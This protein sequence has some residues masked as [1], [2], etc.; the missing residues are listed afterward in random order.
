MSI[1][2]PKGGIRTEQLKRKLCQFPGC[3]DYYMGTGFSKYCGEHRKKQYRKEINKSRLKIE[4]ESANQTIKHNYER[5]QDI[6]YNCELCGESFIIT[7]Y[8]GVTIYPKFCQEHRSEYKRLF[9]KAMHNIIP[10]IPQTPSI[11]IIN[12][13]SI[14]L[15]EDLDII[16]E[17]SAI[18]EV[19]V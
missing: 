1:Q 11:E 19:M 15:E 6:N 10:V 8:P 9:Y 5:P 16:K 13:D 14:D 2:I 17:L 4:T 12:V 7:L 3:T 18:S